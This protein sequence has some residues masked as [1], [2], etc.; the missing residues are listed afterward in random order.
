MSLCVHLQ[1]N[2]AV[3]IKKFNIITLFLEIWIIEMNLQMGET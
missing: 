3:W 2:L 1:N